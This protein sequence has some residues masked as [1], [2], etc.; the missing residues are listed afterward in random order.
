MAH[1]IWLIDIVFPIDDPGFAERIVLF[2]MGKSTGNGESMVTDA[3][4]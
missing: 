3:R 1:L 4:C 2:S